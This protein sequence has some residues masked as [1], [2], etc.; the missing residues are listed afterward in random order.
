[1]GRTGNILNKLYPCTLT[2]SGAFNFFF[3][4]HSTSYGMRCVT[5]EG[6][7]TNSI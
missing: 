1:M 6:Q 7:V 4:K 2:E 3:D 5:N